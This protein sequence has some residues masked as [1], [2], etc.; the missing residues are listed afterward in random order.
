MIGFLIFLFA[1]LYILCHLTFWNEIDLTERQETEGKGQ[2]A[3]GKK[4]RPPTVVESG[5]QLRI[6]RD[7][8]LVSTAL[9]ASLAIALL[10]PKKAFLLAVA[11]YFV[12]VL[13]YS[14]RLKAEPILDV[15]VIAVGFVL[16][17]A[18]G[19][20]AIDVYISPW[21][22]VCTFTL[23]LFLGFSKRLCELHTLSASGEAAKK[24]GAKRKS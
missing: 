10:I 6:V 3:K 19:A 4:N 14:F 17:T 24:T 12:L 2:K 13:A 23:C 9:V 21:L 11:G 20:L 1:Y 5:G 7:H 18:A 8:A 22:M 16:R 15:I